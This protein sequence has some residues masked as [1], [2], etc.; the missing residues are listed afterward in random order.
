M[1][2][3]ETTPPT[4]P[5]MPTRPRLAQGAA[6]ATSALLPVSDST[7]TPFRWVCRIRVQ[8]QRGHSFGTGILIS[9]WHVLTAAHVIFPPQ[10]PYSG[11]TI[12]VGPGYSATS[13][14]VF[15]SNGW[16]ANP[17]WNV[18]ACMTV[19]GDLGLIRLA[20][21]VSPATGF[22]RLAP[23]VP[24]SLTGKPCLLAGYPSR[25]NDPDATVMFRS[26]GRIKGSVVIN[27]CTATTADG[28][29]PPRITQSTL[30]IAHDSASQ[31]SMSGGPLCLIDGGTAKL[32]AVHT[33]AVNNGALKKAVLLNQGVQALIQDWINRTLRPL[34]R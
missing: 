5:R 15:R 23:F 4:T 8:G 25:S 21:P 34:R 6:N 33:G 9:P 26:N 29:I 28:H 19:G 7:R 24:E 31:G 17:R 2:F 22:W 1:Y 32:V 10:E 30:L 13:R 14:P 3:L 20:Q 12:E 27:A 16:A 18:R 11:K